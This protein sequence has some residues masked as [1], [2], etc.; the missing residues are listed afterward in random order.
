MR[1]DELFALRPTAVQRRFGRR[2]GVLVL[3]GSDLI[4]AAVN[5]AVPVCGIDVLRLDLLPCLLRA[6][7]ELDVALQLTVGAFAPIDR[8]VDEPAAVA[9]AL[10]ERADRARFAGPLVLA[11]QVDWALLPVLPPQAIERL[12]GLIDAGF[13]SFQFPLPHSRVELDATL[14]M[15]RIVQQYGLG[16]EAIELPEGA[17]APVL[18]LFA[19]RGIAL[20]AVCAFDGGVGRFAVGGALVPAEQSQ[21]VSLPSATLLSIV[22][23]SLEV[24]VDEAAFAPI[25][26]VA[27]ERIEAVAYA[28][29][30][31]FMR[32]ASLLGS[33][34]SSL[35]E[36]GGV[37]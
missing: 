26:Q 25:D 19:G 20:N 8:G 30:R 21:R 36:L 5:A 23:R 31:R 4:A 13:T 7:E 29:A 34:S 11:T 27:G 6:A 35:A 37:E 32:G 28:E 3:S 18:D 2:S 16:I 24:D 9:G 33:G 22:A 10:L 15:M 14:Q 12:L 1:F 17:L